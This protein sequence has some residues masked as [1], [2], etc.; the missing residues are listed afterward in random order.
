MNCYECIHLTEKDSVD[1][2]KKHC[3]EIFCNKGMKKILSFDFDPLDKYQCEFFEKVK[4][5]KK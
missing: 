3:K 5:K 2:R 1:M 4:K